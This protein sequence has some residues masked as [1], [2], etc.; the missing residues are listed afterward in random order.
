VV[1]TNDPDAAQ[2]FAELY[3]GRAPVLGLNSGGP[4][5]PGDVTRRINEI[6]AYHRQ[7]W[8]LPGGLPPE[9]STV[10][11]MLLTQGF[12]A[13]NDDFGGERLVLFAYPSDLANQAVKMGEIYGDQITL[14]DLA[15]PAQASAG[16]ALPI[17]L[18]WQTLARLTKDYHVFIHLV[19]DEGQII[20]QADGQPALWTRPTTTWVVG[21]TIVDRHGLWIPPQTAPGDYELRIGLYYPTE[22]KRLILEDGNEWV[23]AKVVIQRP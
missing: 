1:I 3:K 4:P 16:T 2:P 14:V 22:G 20:A 7:V 13:R 19:A 10:E 11:Q 17:E 21:E 6:M 15:Y 5:L 23:R 12:R 8:W 9:Q 18:H